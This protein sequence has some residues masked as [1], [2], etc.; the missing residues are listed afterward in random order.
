MLSSSSIPKYTPRQQNQPS[1]NG[2]LVPARVSRYYENLGFKRVLSPIM[3]YKTKKYP[4]VIRKSLQPFIKKVQIHQEGNSIYGWEINPENSKRYILFLHGIKGQSPIPPNQLFIEEVLNKGGYGLITPEY[5][6]SAELHKK[7]FTFKNIVEDAQSTLQYLYAKGIK[8]QDI[9]IVSHCIGSIPAAQI[10]AQ[11]KGIGKIILLS[12]IV[13]GNGFGTTLLK[14]LKLKIPNCI[15]DKLNKLIGLFMP[16]EMN[17]ARQV[18]EISA[19]ITLILPENDSLVSN[20]QCLKLI[21]VIQNL[22]GFITVPKGVHA[23][24]KTNSQAIVSQL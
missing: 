10:A 14:T 9:T 7:T 5:R 1:F 17:T 24:N 22:A 3:D 8:P 15:E 4:Q 23:L 11:E 18:K 21:K 12:P 19:P 2:R 20:Q 6:G 13:D 16:Y